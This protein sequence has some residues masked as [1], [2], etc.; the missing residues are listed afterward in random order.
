MQ[1]T[2]LSWIEPRCNDVIDHSLTGYEIMIKESGHTKRSKTPQ[3]REITWQL[4]LEHYIISTKYKVDLKHM[5]L[6][7]DSRVTIKSTRL[8][9][10]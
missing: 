8:L 5:A 6:A 10:A 1:P 2:Q 7:T 4:F 3:T 9:G